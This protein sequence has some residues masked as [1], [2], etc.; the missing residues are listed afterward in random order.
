MFFNLAKAIRIAIEQTYFKAKYVAKIYDVKEQ[1]PW[2]LH[3]KGKEDLLK[4]GEE[5]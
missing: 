2:W 1:Q 5:K 4:D 3:I